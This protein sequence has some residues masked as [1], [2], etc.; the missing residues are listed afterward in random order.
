MSPRF[1][2][3]NISSLTSFEWSTGDEVTFILAGEDVLQV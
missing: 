1:L 3:G 2:L